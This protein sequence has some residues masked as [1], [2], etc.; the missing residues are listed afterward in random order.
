MM[1]ESDW[2]TV[3]IRLGLSVLLGGIIGIEREIHG[4]SAGLRTHMLVALGSTLFTIVSY[5]MPLHF[6]GDGVGDPTRIAAQIITG[7]GFLGAGTIIQGRGSVHGLT[8]AASIWL[9]SAIG[10]AVG[11]GFYRGALL[12]TVLGNV[13]LVLLNYFENAM[14]RR[15][16][17]RRVVRASLVGAVDSRWFQELV[18]TMGLETYRWHARQTPSGARVLVDGSFRRGDLERFLEALRQKGEVE[19]LEVE[20]R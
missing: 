18:G 1:S 2:T 9:V 8:T 14:I 5:V 12:A 15:K 20:R 19:A 6:R 13:V 10:M 11:G 4:K 7:V 17:S 3:V 16:A